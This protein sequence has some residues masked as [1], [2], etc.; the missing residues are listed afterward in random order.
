MGKSKKKKARARL[1]RA[2]VRLVLLLGAA[3]LVLWV[4]WTGFGCLFRSGGGN[5]NTSLYFYDDI[6][7]T[8]TPIE[9]KISSQPDLATNAV[10]ELI[11][12]P[13]PGEHVRATLNPRTKLIWLKTE[14]G[15]ATVNLSKEIQTR[16]S[17]DVPEKMAIYS[18]I[19][20]LT[21]IKGINAVEFLIDGT[22]PTFFQSSFDASG[23]FTQLLEENKNTRDCYLYFPD[24]ESKYIAV[25]T[26]KVRNVLDPA[27]FAGLVAKR[28][29]QGPQSPY[30]TN[31]FPPSTKVLSVK[32]AEGMLT[33]NLSIEA[34]NQNT[35]AD[36]ELA[37]MQSLVWTLTEI[38]GVRKVKVLVAGK[39][40]D[41]L[42]GHIS[43]FDPIE[44][45]DQVLFDENVKEGGKAV[46]VFL[47]VDMGDGIYLPVP[48]IRSIRIDADPIQ[49]V[50]NLLL[51][52][53]NADERD[54][55]IGTCIPGETKL[56]SIKKEGDHYLVDLNLDTK[57]IQ[58]ASYEAT[59]VRQLVMTI[60]EL[61]KNSA[62][63]LSINGEIRE[64]LP[65]GTKTGTPILRGP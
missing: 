42:G 16:I 55:S 61:D 59:M 23:Q 21:S 52:G 41:T 27:T 35:G 37:M 10:L 56:N 8:L 54:F 28:L 51:Q 33:I 17:S 14:G 64:S 11:K 39:T 1:I 47:S 49:Q 5:N 46:L 12:G 3:F 18:I 50:V 31:V 62:V 60:T 25:E 44:R 15:V 29:I 36:G 4:L 40:A 9:R 57:A 26:A 65:Y 48:R 20:T 13:Q 19:N 6:L 43:T 63:L 7:G 34:R 58:D 22:K 24:L 30:L 2:F 38:P 45:M 53:I 32:L